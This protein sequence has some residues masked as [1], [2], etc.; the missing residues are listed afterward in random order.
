MR[1]ESEF[2]AALTFSD[3]H[4]TCGGGESHS[5]SP[6]DQYFVG[7]QPFLVGGSR[8]ACS[9]QDPHDSRYFSVAAGAPLA[10]GGQN[11]NDPRDDLAAAGA[12]NVVDQRLYE[13]HP[14]LVDGDPFID[15]GLK[16]GGTHHADADID[17]LIELWRQRQAWHV[18]EKR[19]YLQAL[20]ICRRYADG[21][22]KKA[23][24]VFAAATSATPAEP[25]IA[26]AI[27]P[28]V[29]AQ[30]H[31]NQNRKMMEKRL[32][33]L[34]ESLPVWEAWA[35]DVRGFGA[36]SLASIVGECGDLGL[37]GNPA[38]LWKRLGLA[39]IGGE[40]QRKKTDKALAEL[41]GYNPRRRSVVWVIGSTIIKVGGETSPYRALYLERKELEAT[42]VASKA[43]AHNRAARYMTKRLVR[44]L[45]MQW[46]R[47]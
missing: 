12:E 1:D 9:D 26:V 44:D 37:Y 45:W 15:V 32:K 16:K 35:K 6:A 7:D 22:K 24:A 47:A 25:L 13:T 2:P 42:R 43:H 19:L 41:H 28:L 36:L 5:E 33:A 40:R 20:A 3:A 11:G 4:T 34:A 29:A 8:N 17:E 10:G 21:D 23:L 27:A 18:A 39:V 38:K 14:S 46:R 30:E 31:I